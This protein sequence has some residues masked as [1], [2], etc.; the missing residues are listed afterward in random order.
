MVGLYE[1]IQMSDLYLKRMSQH[2]TQPSKD[3]I[4]VFDVDYTLYDNAEL[5]M[6]EKVHT[7]S[8][9]TVLLAGISDS[10]DSIKKEY[11]SL[12]L[13]LMKKY[14]ILLS[15]IKNHEFLKAHE[16][17][18][19]DLE[20]KKLLKRIPLKKYGLTNAFKQR[21]VPI[22][23]AL[24]V[25]DCF[26]KVYCAND[27]DKES[28]LIRKPLKSA[29][30]FV[31]KD[32]NISKDVNVY[33]FDDLPENIAAAQKEGWDATLI[34]KD[35]PIH[36]AMEDFIKKHGTEYGIED[37]GN[38]CGDSTCHCKV[39]RDVNPVLENM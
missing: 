1:I 36:V 30:Q 17:L 14:N 4:M 37:S 20:L 24:D 16:Y 11:G 25:E 23:S 32:L 31:T 2:V 6:A 39:E 29:Y 34:T 10:F 5:R 27:D 12:V 8:A 22:L 38:V 9:E 21:V 35:Y 15:T 7:K 33:F 26:E 18:I 13:G 28:L 3:D 19:P